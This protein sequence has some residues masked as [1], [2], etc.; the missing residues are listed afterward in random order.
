MS[1]DSRPD[2]RKSR[3]DLL[4]EL[5]YLRDIAG[6]REQQYLRQQARADTSERAVAERD[7]EVAALRRQ[8]ELILHSRSWRLTAPLRWLS[9]H[10]GRMRVAGGSA[11]AGAGPENA[12][13]RS[14]GSTGP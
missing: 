12:P 13:V 11:D 6:E 1:N 8:L 14:R 2:S 4:D 7:S 9:K 10:V 3:Q 5:Y